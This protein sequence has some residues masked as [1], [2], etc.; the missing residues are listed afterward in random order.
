M[1][2]RSTGGHALCPI[3]LS[4]PSVVVRYGDSVTINCSALTNQNLGIGWESITGG[5]GLSK[6]SLLTWTV[7]RLTDWNIS[8]FCYIYPSEGA[9]FTQCPAKP[10]IVLYS[11]F[12]V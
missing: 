5:V 4:P 12:H 11:E 1:L 9:H 3:E 10:T 2:M 7:E 8:P 6:V